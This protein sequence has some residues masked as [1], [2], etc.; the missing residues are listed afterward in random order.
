MRISGNCGH[1]LLAIV[2]FRL[3]KN[4]S[5]SS[6]H[7]DGEKKNTSEVLEEYTILVTCGNY[8]TACSVPSEPVK[9]LVPEPPGEA[10]SNIMLS[11]ALTHQF[12]GR[13]TSTVSLPVAALKTDKS[14][15]LIDCW[16][17]F[18]PDSHV[19]LDCLPPNS[20]TNTGAKNSLRLLVVFVPREIAAVESDGSSR[21]REDNFFSY[22]QRSVATLSTTKQQTKA[23]AAKSGAGGVLSTTNN[24]K[25][26]PRKISN[27]HYTSAHRSL[28][29]QQSGPPRTPYRQ[30]PLP[31][32]PTTLPPSAEYA[33]PHPVGPPQAVVVQKGASLPPNGGQFFPG[34][35]QQ[36]PPSADDLH[37]PQQYSTT[38]QFN[39]ILIHNHPRS[40]NNIANNPKTSKSKSLVESSL[41]AERVDRSL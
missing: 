23:A 24:I 5:S 35:H 7:D 39:S 11:L 37:N 34:L 25:G 16:V 21:C 15:E 41:P 3:S 32:S 12:S 1:L 22:L 19:I 40:H 9:L 31:L 27:N 36:P 26:I 18:S 20:E 33:A 30:Q 10:D 2:D 29:H 14:C 4:L 6:A 17:P 13:A 38:N 28:Q 8:G